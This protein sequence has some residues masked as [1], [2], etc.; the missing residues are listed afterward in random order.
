MKPVYE[1]GKFANWIAP[2]N[3]GIEGRPVEF[4]YVRLN[5]SGLKR[6]GP[7]RSGASSPLTRRIGCGTY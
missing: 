1:P 4:E 5:D 6:G 2:P 7:G 3:K